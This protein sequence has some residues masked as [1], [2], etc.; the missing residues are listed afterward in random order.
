MSFSYTID[1]AN[2]VVYTSY[3][4]T[5]T[6]EVVR[7]YASSLSKDPA[8]DPNFADVC[9]LSEVSLM[10]LDLEDFAR[11]A[12]EVDPFSREA[13]RAF[14]VRNDVAFVSSELYRALRDSEKTQLF[15]SQAEARRWL[16]LKG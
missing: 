5:I 1:S 9:D 11:I 3:M 12:A 16:G 10:T 15:S 4:G 14:V 13:K 7:R 8:F 6:M 2:R